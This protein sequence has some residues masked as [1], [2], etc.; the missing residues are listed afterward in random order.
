MP[1]LLP[2]AINGHTI[3][4]E[5]EP[6]YGIEDTTSAD[7]ALDQAEDAFERAKTTVTSMAQGRDYFR[8]VLR[9]LRGH[10]IVERPRNLP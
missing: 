3:Y 6:T 8:A 5:A 9:W 2:V 1:N 10:P 7:K 4:I